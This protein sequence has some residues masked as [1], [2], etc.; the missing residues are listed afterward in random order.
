MKYVLFDFNGT[1]V[2]DVALSLEAINHT[3]KKYLNRSEIKLEE[4]RNIFT[5]PVKAYYEALGFDFNKLN[6]EETGSVWFNYYQEH[7]D[8][9]KLHDGVKELLIKNHEKGYKNIVLSASKKDLL[10]EQLKEL[11][12]Y[13]YFDDVL[14]IDNIY[15]S[16][17]LP[18]GLKFIEDKD[19]NECVLIGDSGHDKYVADQMGIKS[20]LVANG[21]ESKE[22]LLKI[23]NDVYDNI[24]EV[25]LWE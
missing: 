20:I 12:V 8:K 25:N 4:Y 6:W 1:I 18:I 23:S 15:A 2:D 22:R 24:K 14:G 16:S 21:H 3:A 7:K 11:G 13:E 10:I 5:F 9:A 19:P 17:K